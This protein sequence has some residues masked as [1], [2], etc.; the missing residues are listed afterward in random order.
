MR[1]D[2][3]LFLGGGVLLYYVFLKYRIGLG[4]NP[5]RPTFAKGA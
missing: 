3:L 4:G 5:L 2:H 1:K